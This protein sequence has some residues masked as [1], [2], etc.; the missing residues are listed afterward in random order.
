MICFER[1]EVALLLH[2]L[3]SP[4]L[5]CSSVSLS[6]RHRNHILH[7]SHPPSITATQILPK[8]IFF[9]TNSDEIQTKIIFSVYLN[10]TQK[11]LQHLQSHR[12]TNP[13]SNSNT[14]TKFTSINISCNILNHNATGV[15]QQPFTFHHQFLIEI[16]SFFPAPNTQKTG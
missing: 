16:F 3:L 13:Y 6:T 1:G 5:K 11:S 15:Q 4:P 8:S 12:T 7:H 2:L 10:T 14:N 9:N